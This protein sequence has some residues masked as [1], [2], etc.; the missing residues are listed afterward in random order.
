MKKS[1][2]LYW[3]IT[4]LFA[5]FM[6]FSAIPNIISEPESVAM[7]T[8]LGYPKYFIPF[9]GVAKVIGAIAILLPGLRRL[10]EWAYAGLFFDLFSATYS[11]LASQPLQTGVLFMFVFMG[12]LFFSYYLWHKKIGTS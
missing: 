2:L 4:G 7:I 12:F 1:N 5:A 8:G 10:K 11:I 9:I 6:I 3:I